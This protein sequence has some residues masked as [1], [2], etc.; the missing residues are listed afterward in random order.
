MNQSNLFISIY[1]LPSTISISRLTHLSFAMT[2]NAPP[3]VLSSSPP[4]SSMSPLSL[5]LGTFNVGRGLTRKLPHIIHR[6]LSLSLDIIALQEIGD[7]ALLSTKFPQY[8]LTYTPGPSLQEAGV[9]LLI[10][11]DLAPRCR[12]FKRSKSGRLVGVVIELEQGRPTLIISSYMPSGLDHQPLSSTTMQHAHTLY[13][14]M[15][16]WALNMPRVIVMGDLN[17]TMTPADRIPHPLTHHHSSPAAAL[18]ASPIQCLQHERFTDAYRLLHPHAAHSP[19]FTHEIMSERRHIRSRIDYIWTRGYD[20]LSHISINIDTKLQPYSH[21]HL[22]WMEIQ[23]QLQHHATHS[24][25]QLPALYSQQLPNLRTA[26]DQHKKNFINQLEKKMTQ[27]QHTQLQQLL[28][29]ASPSSALSSLASRLTSLSHCAA[30]SS[31]PIT[32]S[33][34]YRS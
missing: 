21:H 26:T 18:A 1:F 16:Q 12:S 34:Q 15:T 20:P 17:Q 33:T 28:D 32:G 27:H 6:C 19:G 3:S 14:E 7:P 24:R 31:L 29:D 25:H 5:R 2:H 8:F 22:L 11:N 9:A 23:Q 4:P 30:L 10:S 13:N